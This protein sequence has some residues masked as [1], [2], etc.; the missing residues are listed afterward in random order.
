MILFDEWRTRGIVQTWDIWSTV[1]IIEK[2]CIFVKGTHTQ[3][4]SRKFS[5]ILE[6]EKQIMRSYMGQEERTE[7][8]TICWFSPLRPTRPWCPSPGPE[9]SQEQRADLSSPGWVGGSHLLML[10]WCHRCCLLVSVWLGSGSEESELGTKPSDTYMGCEHV[11]V[12]PAVWDLGAV[13]KHSWRPQASSSL[14]NDRVT[15]VTGCVML[16]ISSL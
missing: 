6:V 3:K 8:I 9:W 10:Y 13:S 1:C 4:E 2:P 15:R 12:T 14:L 5:C 7:R 16:L 11:T